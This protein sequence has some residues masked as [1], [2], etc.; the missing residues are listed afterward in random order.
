[1]LTVI[2]KNS[3]HYYSAL[4]LPAPT[5]YNASGRGTPDVSA[6]GVGFEV[7]VCVCV[8][9]RMRMLCL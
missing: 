2:S 9:V 5:R 7:R 6:L 4:D 8:R 3:N 1:M